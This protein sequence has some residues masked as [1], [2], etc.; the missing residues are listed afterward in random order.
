MNDDKPHEYVPQLAIYNAQALG[1]K[2]ALMDSLEVAEA[3]R[4]NLAEAVREVNARLV[5]VTAERDAAREWA[6]TDMAEVKPN[7]SETAF[8]RGY[9]HALERVYGIARDGMRSGRT[10]AEVTEEIG[11]LC[12]LALEW[13][14]SYVKG[15]S[16]PFLP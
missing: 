6:M 10:I 3:E 5:E 1:E 13:R 2:I 4:N 8:R 15:L 14:E 9:V 7:A 16:T 11:Q 12:D